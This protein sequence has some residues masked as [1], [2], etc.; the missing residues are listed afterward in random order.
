LDYTRFFKTKEDFFAGS[1]DVA[2]IGAGHAG[3][4]AALISAYLGAKTVCFTVNLDAAGNMPCNPAIGGTGKGHLVREL[5]ALGGAMAHFADSAALQYRTLNR[6]KGAA[7]HSLR[8]QCDRTRYRETVKLALESR[9]NLD[10]KQAEITDIF[11]ENGRVAAIRTYGGAVYAVRSVVVATGTFLEGRTITGASIRSGGPDG[12]FAAIGLSGSLAAL[13]VALR[14]FKTGTPPRVNANS[15]DFSKM[16]EQPG[17]D[18]PQPCSFTAHTIPENRTVCHLTYTNEKTHAIIREN[19]H[20]S[21]LYGGVIEGTGPRYCPSIEDKVVRF[22]DKPRHQ[23]FVEP[24]GESTLELYIQGFSSSMPEDVQIK[25]LRTLPGLERAE[26]QRPAYAIEYDCCDPTQLT[27][28]LEFKAIPG[29]YGAGQF[30]GSSGYEEAAVQGFVAGANAALSVLGREPLI[31]SRA[32]GYIGVL[33]DDL[34]TK[35][36][37]EP[38]RIMTSRTEFRLY[39]RQDNADLRLSEIAARAGTITEERRRAVAQKYAAVDGELARLGK[40]FVPPSDELNA[41]LAAAGETGVTTGVSLLLLLRRPSVT[42]NALA[43]LDTDRPRLSREIAESVEIT[44]KYE[45]Y[46]ERQKKQI[47]QFR[48]LESYPLPQDLDYAAIKGLRLEARQKLAQIKPVSLGQA[49]R[50]SGVSPA[51]SAVL[52]IFLKQRGNKADV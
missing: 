11:A 36:T 52:M 31:I 50:V 37:N 27:A 44:V 49:M 18:D 35:G 5:D 21:P 42:Y 6:G 23:I 4:E 7:V 13:G 15:A 3:A 12:M 47:E 28:T 40:C 29:L 25:M 43:A 20:R 9:E 26:L 46:I 2:V 32:D 51:D 1:Y 17:D 19:L 10:F 33:I 14:R 41:I 30:N 16:A 38:Y 24:M 34:V 8:V 45:G 39:H 48:K 22:A